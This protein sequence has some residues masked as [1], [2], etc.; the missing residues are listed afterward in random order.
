MINIIPFKKDIFSNFHIDSKKVTRYT[1]ITDTNLIYKLLSTDLPIKNKRIALIN[2]LDFLTYIDDRVLQDGSTLIG[3]KSRK[4]E[5]F[6]SRGEYKKYMI[7]LDE[8]NILTRVPYPDGTLFSKEYKIPSQ[9]RIHND[10]INSEDLSIV[11][12]E[13]DRSKV[14]FTNEVDNI[15]ERYINTIKKIEINIPLA[16][17]AEIDNFIKGNTTFTKLRSRISKIFYTKQRRF[18]KMGKTVNRIYHS[19]TNVSRV[20]RKY[21]N[22]N[23]IDVDIVNCQPLL[24]VAL[25]EKNNMKYDLN[26]KDDCENGRFYEL[27]Y[28]IK[29]D[30]SIESTRKNTKVSIYKNIFFGFNKISRYNKRFKELYPYTWN[31]LST[32]NDSDTSLASQLQ[33]LESDLFNKIIPK[34]SNHYFTLFDSIYFD[35]VLDQHLI[36]SEIKK[37]FMSFNIKVKT[38]KD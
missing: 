24:L 5:E 1:Y 14:K 9:Y 23:M 31:S 34:E 15:D 19:F 4:I 6:F 18:I 11:I 16:I 38:N 13:D 7:I 17:E 22:I 2:I 35:N 10:Y 3:I 25:L 27:F 37:Y 36:L 32:I 28:D 29:P 20:S 26:Y 33:N 21:L 8:L 30:I 12:L